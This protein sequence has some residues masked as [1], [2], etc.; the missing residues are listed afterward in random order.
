MLDILPVEIHT[1]GWIKSST[2]VSVFVFL[3]DNGHVSVEIHTPGWIKSSVFVSV[4]VFL[5]INGHV[6]AEIHTQGWIEM[7]PNTRLVLTFFA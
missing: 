7:H 6:S 5:L 4:F 2:F 3:L 1:P